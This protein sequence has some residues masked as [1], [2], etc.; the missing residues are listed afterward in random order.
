MP[1]PLRVPHEIVLPLVR[2]AAQ[3]SEE[4][5]ESRIVV[6]YVS[7]MA[8]KSASIIVK[9]DL[10]S[11]S[12]ALDTLVPRYMGAGHLVSVAEYEQASLKTYWNRFVST[13]PEPYRA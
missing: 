10:T 11:R 7:P 13:H 4:G 2:L 3:A 5:W 12:T 1:T 9:K 8:F 6:V